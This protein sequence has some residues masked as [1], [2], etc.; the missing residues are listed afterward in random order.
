MF[1]NIIICVCKYYRFWYVVKF[2]IFSKL[3]VRSYLIGVKCIYKIY[4]YFYMFYCIELIWSV[5]LIFLFGF[6]GLIFIKNF[7]L[8]D[9]L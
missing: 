9:F 1:I 6:W 5:I 2:K 7:I 4:K 3:G 8:L